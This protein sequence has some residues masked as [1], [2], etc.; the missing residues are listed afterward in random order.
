MTVRVGIAGLRG[1][2]G[3]EI[4]A[5][6]VNDPRIMVVGG[7]SRRTRDGEP[8]PNGIPLFAE[9]ADLLSEV[10]VL[11][12]FSA[13]EGSIIHASACASSGVPLVCGTTGLNASQMAELRSAAE[14][15]AVFHA[16]NMSA[17]VNAA[18]AVLPML[19]RALQDYDVE[20]LESHHRHKVDAPSGT[21]M[22]LARVV[23]DATGGDLEGRARYGRE[24]ASLREPGEIGILAIR[25]G[26]NPG[27]H[28]V[29]LAGDGEEIRLSHRAFSRVSYAEGALRA[30]RLIANQAP[31][32]YEP[33]TLPGFL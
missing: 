1:R 5:L 33:T 17:G 25:A 32:W 22:A 10:D 26:G 29:I 30:A 28:T 8:G 18:L 13:P 4:A 20:I 16:A 11:I 24:G 3:H 23:A 9:T 6:G 31:G 21:A 12:D 15:V 2:M 19:V 14:R 7:L 27:E